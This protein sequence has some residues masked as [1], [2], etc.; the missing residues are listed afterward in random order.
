MG[1]GG[2]RRLFQLPAPCRQNQTPL[3]GQ[4][5]PKAD[6]EGIGSAGRFFPV[7]VKHP[8]LCTGKRNKLIL[9]TVKVFQGIVLTS[10]SALLTLALSPD[11]FLTY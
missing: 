5:E 2:V 4:S 8:S 9:L 3:G 10:F 11:V 7:P 6:Q 1:V